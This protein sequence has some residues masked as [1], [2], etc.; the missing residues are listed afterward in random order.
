MDDVKKRDPYRQDSYTQLRAVVELPLRGMRVL[1]VAD[2]RAYQRELAS[3]LEAWGAIVVVADDGVAA[4]GAIGERTPDAVLVDY[5]SPGGSGDEVAR[6]L[7]YLPTPPPMFLFT[8]S[9][10]PSPAISS[11][12]YVRWLQKPV[13]PAILRSA[14]ELLASKPTRHTG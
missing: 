5:D 9:D 4:L 2:G 1:V 11:G 8:S 6:A 13:D 7:S 3:A 14:L 10:A 12:G